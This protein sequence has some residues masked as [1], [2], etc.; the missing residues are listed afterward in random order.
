MKELEPQSPIDYPNKC[1]GCGEVHRDA[2]AGRWTKC[3]KCA[4]PRVVN[5][6]YIHFVTGMTD[7]EL[8]ATYAAQRQLVS[9]YKQRRQRARLIAQEVYR[10][11]G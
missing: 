8:E 11:E 6:P 2:D 4:G 3:A 7:E 5:I 10:G 1:I 9:E